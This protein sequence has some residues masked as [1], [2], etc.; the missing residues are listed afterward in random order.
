MQWLSWWHFQPAQNAGDE[1]GSLLT[2]WLCRVKTKELP[3]RPQA[4]ESGSSA[5]STK[6]FHC[7]LSTHH[8]KYGKLV[9]QDGEENHK[10]I[11][12][13]FFLLLS[14]ASCSNHLNIFFCF[15]GRKKNVTIPF[16][17]SFREALENIGS[18][19]KRW[20]EEERRASQA[21]RR[22][23]IKTCFG[24]LFWARRFWGVERVNSKVSLILIACAGPHKRHNRAL[25]LQEQG[26]RSET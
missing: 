26:K 9:E 15:C 11:S 24:T 12:S 1:M 19:S 16:L 20:R 6:A 25:H 18:T 5:S 22:S 21:T 8:L 17:F 14:A 10:V 2:V 13:C 23:Q 7:A 3:W 4:P